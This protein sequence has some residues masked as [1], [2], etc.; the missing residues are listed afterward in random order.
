MVLFKFKNFIYKTG[1]IKSGYIL[2]GIVIVILIIILQSAFWYGNKQTFKAKITG[3]ERITTSDSEGKVS[4]FYLIYTNKGS[5]TL[6]DELFYGNFNSSDTYGRIM[7][8]STYSIT[9][10][11]YRLGLT[12][13]YSNI[14]NIE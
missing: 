9:T 7:Q 3:K 11:G 12:S 10:I 1:N 2:G 13:T 14:V 5:F 6:K 8:D 4:S